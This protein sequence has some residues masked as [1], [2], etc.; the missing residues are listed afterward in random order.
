[1]LDQIEVL[2]TRVRREFVPP[3]ERTVQ[4]ERE[5]GHA[6]LFPILVAGDEGRV[7]PV[8]L[9]AQ[10]HPCRAHVIPEVVV[11]RRQIANVAV[12]FLVQDGCPQRPVVTERLVHHRLESLPAPLPGAQR[13]G[14]LRGIQVR[15]RRDDVDRSGRSVASEQQ[16]LR[17]FQHL[18][19]LQVKVGAERGAVAAV[20]DAVGVQ[21]QCGFRRGGVRTGI[22]APH[23]DEHV[24]ARKAPGHARHGLH[25]LLRVLD[26]GLPQRLARERRNRDRHFL[27][28]L[29]ALLRGDDDLFQHRAGV[30]CRPGRFLRVSPEA[31]RGRHRRGCRTPNVPSGCV[32]VPVPNVNT[33]SCVRIPI[34]SPT[35]SRHGRGPCPD[36]LLSCPVLRAAQADQQA[37]RAAEV[38]RRRNFHPSTRMGRDRSGRAYAIP[39]SRAWSSRNATIASSTSRPGAVFASNASRT[40]MRRSTPRSS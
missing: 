18:D 19:A 39:T 9:V 7:A 40:R 6:A 26:A 22:D 33:L 20:I 2:P 32:H 35:T 3:E 5:V 21:A 10:G 37:A 15:L 34:R 24:V 30:A 8:V 16:A 14:S 1:M 11:A 25:Q 13:D 27:D 12:L 4:V 31:K 36:T 17:T 38:S 23:R 29:V 28:R